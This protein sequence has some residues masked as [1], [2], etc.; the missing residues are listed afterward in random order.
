[1]KNPDTV[2]NVETTIMNATVSGSHAACS[3]A[4]LAVNPA[5][6]PIAHQ[7]KWS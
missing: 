3:G 4:S 1:M 6:P 5:T 2:V 7:S